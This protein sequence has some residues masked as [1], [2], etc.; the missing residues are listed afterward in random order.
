MRL[1]RGTVRAAAH[2]PGGR[3]RAD[4]VRALPFPPRRPLRRR[5]QPRRHPAHHLR[6]H[7]AGG[8][9]PAARSRSAWARRCGRRPAGRSMSCCGLAHRVGNAEGA[10]AMLPT[11][12]RWAFALMIVGGL[13]LCLWTGRVRAWGCRALRARRARRGNGAGPEPAGHRRRPASRPGPRRW[14]AGAAAQPKRRFRPRPDERGLGI[15]RRSGS[16]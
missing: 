1:A 2:R 3:D 16:A 10:V 7:A 15:R 9:R 11:M 14:R 5:R 12:P 8:A 13:W 4:P 6:H